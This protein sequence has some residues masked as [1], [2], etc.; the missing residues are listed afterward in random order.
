MSDKDESS[1]VKGIS[2]TPVFTALFKPAAEYLGGELREFVKNKLEELKE[3]RRAK[4]LE[5]HFSAVRIRITK[6]TSTTSAPSDPS[7]EQIELFDEWID[8]VQDVNPEDQELSELWQNLLARAV[9]G[10]DISKEI[11][12]VL[13][14]LTPMEA[15]NL[16]KIHKEGTLTSSNKI[17]SAEQFYARSLEDKR[18][19]AN[20]FSPQF[21]LI[22][23]LLFIS[24]LLALVAAVDI[25]PPS[26]SDLTPIMLL[27]D[28]MDKNPISSITFGFMLA[29][30]CV[31]LYSF[32]SG[33]HRCW[34]LSWIG[35]ELVRYASPQKE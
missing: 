13:K 4:N 7:L 1:S 12:R 6:I 21:F 17:I 34:R 31:L 32:L 29:C 25:T 15:A 5:A 2:H 19:I 33:K 3:A 23:T 28:F 16:L 22:I 27:G 24:I 14:T 10:E 26:S 11:L 8:G 9:I 18:I 30:L 20:F 35:R